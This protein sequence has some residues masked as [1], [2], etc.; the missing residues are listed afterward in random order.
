MRGRA[1]ESGERWSCASRAG[2]FR[3]FHHDALERSKIA[4]VLSTNPAFK[5]KASVGSEPRIRMKSEGKPRSWRMAFLEMGTEMLLRRVFL[6]GARLDNTGG[7]GSL[8]IVPRSVLPPPLQPPLGFVSVFPDTCGR[9]ERHIVLGAI[10][11][12]ICGRKMRPVVF[13]AVPVRA[14]GRDQGEPRAVPT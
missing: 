13:R 5:L 3:G 1:G 11:K 8:G 4:V 9:F 12:P 7:P 14:C 10:S 6:G 2:Y